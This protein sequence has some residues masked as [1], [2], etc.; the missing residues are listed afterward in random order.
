MPIRKVLTGTFDPFAC[1]A[2]LKRL[3]PDAAPSV[4]LESAKTTGPMGRYSIV[5]AQPFMTL[6][7]RDDVTTVT[8]KN[9]KTKTIKANPFDVLQSLLEAYASEP[10]TD[11][12]F[13]GG[14][15]GC[16]CYEAK[17]WVEPKLPATQPD[18]LR[19]PDLYFIFVDHGVVFDHR[20]GEA[21]IFAETV[22]QVRKLEKV[23]T[24]TR[25]PMPPA[26]P[27][28]FPTEVN[29]PLTKSS[30]CGIVNKA[31]RYI[32]RGDIFQANLSQRFDFSLDADP[33]EIY[34]RLKKT[35]PS[36]FF[37][38]LDAGTF[39]II[40]GSPERLLSL[41]EGV[42][43]TR[44][45]AGTRSR[46]K[47]KTEDKAKSLELLLNEKERAEHIMLV[48]LERN[49]LGRV[50]E[51]GSVVVDELMSVEDYTHVKHIVSNVKARLKRSAGAVDA[52]K[53]FFP[54]GTITGAPKIRC[55]EI[56]DELEPVA[57]GPYTGSL[58]YFSFSGNMDFNIII[59]SL[60]LKQGRAYLQVGAGIVADSSPEK[61]YDETLYKAESVLTALF[62]SKATRSF[63]ERCRAG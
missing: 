58:G 30:F 38:V 44:P 28:I 19:L 3:T 62:G 21:V 27:R 24:G 48:D 46:G 15:I 20:K 16:V 17:K 61:E 39:Q 55:M 35:N 5:A 1:Y 59:R 52:F 22:S 36:P 56:I 18:D 32:E 4:L 29:R 53:A 57:R 33:L 47:N 25:S 8:K 23:L 41:R 50:S 42:L 2:S 9:Q 7:A 14:A 26:P 43:E 54:G 40:S 31:K 6:E 12:P 13:M 63:F 49:D 45:I 11:I 60:V 51:Y 10:V 37:G 34:S